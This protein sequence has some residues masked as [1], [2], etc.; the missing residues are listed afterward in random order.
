MGK[1]KK[2]QPFGMFYDTLDTL[3]TVPFTIPFVIP[4]W[5]CES[6]DYMNEVGLVECKFCGAKIPDEFCDKY[7][8]EIEG[9]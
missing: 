8:I 7:Q 2:K 1:C 5:K 4:V 6:C 3:L 9:L